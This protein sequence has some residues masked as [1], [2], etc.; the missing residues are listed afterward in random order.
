VVH[1]AAALSV[2]GGRDARRQPW[3]PARAG[4]WMACLCCIRPERRA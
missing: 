1:T 4:R 2:L 3:R